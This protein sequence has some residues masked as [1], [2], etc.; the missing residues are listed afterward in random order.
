MW[1]WAINV[2]EFQSITK[3]EA[4]AT[5]FTVWSSKKHI[6]IF[7]PV[8]RRHEAVAKAVFKPLSQNGAEA[9][10]FLDTFFWENKSPC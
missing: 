9:L 1:A 4:V 10:F 2:L 6:K 5:K 8:K 7:M 3:K